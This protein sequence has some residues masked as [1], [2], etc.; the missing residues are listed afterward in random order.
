MQERGRQLRLHVCYYC[1][2]LFVCALTLFRLHV[3]L[4]GGFSCGDHSAGDGAGGVGGLPVRGAVRGDH[5]RRAVRPRGRGG[6]QRVHGRV[7]LRRVP[8]R[9]PVR[10]DGAR[11]GP[12]LP[13]QV[14]G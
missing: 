14:L 13:L 7:P 2:F 1:S 6:E 10:V 4:R 11:R 3:R 8:A 9:R 12:G 5:P